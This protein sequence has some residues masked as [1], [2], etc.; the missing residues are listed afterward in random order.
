MTISMTKLLAD[1]ENDASTNMPVLAA[2]IEASRTESFA[3]AIARV[4]AETVAD[5]DLEPDFDDYEW[6][7]RYDDDGAGEQV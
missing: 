2:N 6:A 1:F 4:K 3:D 7:D 5:D